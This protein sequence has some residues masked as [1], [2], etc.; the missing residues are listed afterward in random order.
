MKILELTGM[1]STKYGGLEKFNVALTKASPTDKFIFVY[2][3]KPHVPAYINDLQKHHAKIIIIPTSPHK[4]Y[5]T[6]I[7]RLIKKEKPDIVHFHFGG[8][9]LLVAPI[10][11]ILFPKIKQVATYHSEY[12][13]TK[14]IHIFLTRIF[15]L[16]QCHVIAVS[17]GVRHGLITR[18]GN[19][20]KFD[21]SY[22]GVSCDVSNHS[23]KQDFGID[24]NTI[25]MTSIGFDITI[26]GFDI[27][28]KSVK[29]LTNKPV[30]PNF[31]II[32]VGLDKQREADYLVMLRNLGIE[33]RF[34]LLGIRNDIDY[35]LDATDIYLQPSR[36]EG[37]PLSIMEAINHGLPIIATNVGGIPEI[38]QHTENGILTHPSN[39]EELAVAIEELIINKEKRLQLRNKSKAL[40][41]RFSRENGVERLKKIYKSI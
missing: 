12:L 39:V 40:S 2:N 17:E 5:I 15:L 10:I 14:K 28:A 1:D 33:N 13:S 19:K 24:K 35:I 34:I 11:K 6:Q 20:R 29:I 16:C 38:V 18:F 9:K 31:K 32:I 22:L 23:T 26:K 3:S 37:L 27:I 21:V 30:I 8:L 36:T 7:I 4:K 41:A 25:V